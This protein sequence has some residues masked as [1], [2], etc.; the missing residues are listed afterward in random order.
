MCV[1]CWLLSVHS[2]IDFFFISYLLAL[3]VILPKRISSRGFQTFHSPFKLPANL[4]KITLSHPPKNFSQARTIN[5]KF[6]HRF[7]NTWLNHKQFF[8]FSDIYNIF[9]NL[10]WHK[11]IFNFLIFTRFLDL[12]FKSTFFYWVSEQNMKNIIWPI[13]PS[14][15]REHNWKIFLTLHSLEGKLDFTSRVWTR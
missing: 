13:M 11:K 5:L 8:I 7:T 2:F 15:R 4:D 1:F 6:F 14:A 12:C 3:N 9:I 10:N